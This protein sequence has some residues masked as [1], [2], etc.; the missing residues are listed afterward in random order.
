MADFCHECSIET[1]GEDFGDLKGIGKPGVTLEPGYG[2]QAICE[3]CGPILVDN[4]GKKIQPEKAE[5]SPI[6]E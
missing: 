5:K 1:F 2:W 6:P 3:G 4:E